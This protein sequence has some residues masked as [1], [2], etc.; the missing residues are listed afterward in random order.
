MENAVDGESRAAA[1]GVDDRLGL[2]R[3]QHPHAE[4]DDPARREI[5]A[6]LALRGF[7]D[8]VF[9]RL[10]HDI[11]VRVEE[12]PLF[13]RA[14]ADLQVLGSEADFVVV[15]N[16]IPFLAGLVEEVLNGLLRLG[17]GVHVPE[18]EMRGEVRVAGEFVVKLRED[19]LEH[20]LEN[21]HAR[22]REHLVLKVFDELSEA[23]SLAAFG[24]A[25]LLVFQKR[26]DRPRLTGDHLDRLVCAG[27]R[28]NFLEV[29]R[30][31]PVPDDD[32]RTVAPDGQRGTG[33]VGVA[34]ELFLAAFCGRL[35]HLDD[36]VGNRRTVSVE[37]HDVRPLRA[38]APKSDRIFHLNP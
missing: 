38:V 20:L 2:L 7:V 4:V 32:L 11:E 30:V 31:F 37:N 25:L 36:D 8:E 26:V 6:L 13:Q 33:R 16:A 5:L 21:I 28:G 1:G 12:L 29:V 24:I 17:G 3:V 9:E 19:E 10:V 22:I 35:L 34:L 18:S 23:P 14:D 15:K 27:Q